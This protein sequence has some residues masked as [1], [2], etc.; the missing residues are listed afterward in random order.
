[1]MQIQYLLK[2]NITLQELT[3]EIGNFYHFMELTE[4]LK[5]SS[6]ALRDDE[7]MSPEIQK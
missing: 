6:K 3:K 4:K 1:M 5:P 2:K 7:Y